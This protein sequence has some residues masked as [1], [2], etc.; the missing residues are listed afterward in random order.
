MIITILQLI[1]IF[2]FRLMFNI[3]LITQYLLM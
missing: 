1:M 2:N 3:I